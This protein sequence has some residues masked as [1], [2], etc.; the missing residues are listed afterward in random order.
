[1]RFAGGILRDRRLIVAAAVIVFVV[2]SISPTIAHASPDPGLGSSNDAIL[3][4]ESIRTHLSE[5]PRPTPPV[6]STLRSNSTSDL[7]KI[8]AQRYSTEMFEF[9]QSFPWEA[10]L[11][12]WGCALVGD[13][14]IRINEAPNAGGVA[15]PSVEF[16]STCIKVGDVPT[17]SSVTSLNELALGTSKSDIESSQLRASSCPVVISGGSHCL[18]IG[19]GRQDATYTWGG[20]LMHG[21]LELGTASVVAPS[22][23]TANPAA[24]GAFNTYYNN[25]QRSIGT[26]YSLSANWFFAFRQST[27]GGTDVGIRS[28][29]CSN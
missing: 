7:Q 25:D 10:G 14:E 17:V 16:G 22:C 11:A 19:S 12:Q 29:L 20:T 5:F 4:A 24:T 2:S 26:A 23:N 9:W 27:N 28:Y 6:D 15:F 3:A 18:S 8:L 21:R 1:M 13:V